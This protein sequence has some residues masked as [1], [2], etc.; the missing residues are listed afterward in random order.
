MRTLDFGYISKALGRGS[1]PLS[2]IASSVFALT[3][4]FYIFTF[5][6]YFKISIYTLQNR[7]TYNTSFEFYIIDKYID[8][9]IVISGTVLWLILCLKGKAR[10]IASGI[11]GAIIVI[12]LALNQNI[13]LDICA[14]V[15]V[16]LMIFFLIRHHMWLV[17][18]DK[19]ISNIQNKLSLNYLAVIGIIT[20]TISI[21]MILALILIPISLNSIPIPNYAYNIFVLF[22]SFSPVFLFL[23][24]DSFPTKLVIRELKAIVYKPK[25]K[26]NNKHNKGIGSSLLHFNSYIKPHQKLI[27]L[28]FFM[29]LSMCMV[30]IPHLPS[31]NADKQKVGVD[32][33]FYVSWINALIR[34]NDSWQFLQQAFN[35]QAHGDR[36]LTL[37]LLFAWAKISSIDL[38]Q[39]IEYVPLILGPMLVLAVYFLTRELIPNNDS[40]AL[41]ASFITAI[42]FQT[43]IGIYSGFYANWIALIV[44]YLALV[45]LLR[46]LKTSVKLNLV[47]FS[48]LMIVLLFAHVYTWSILIIVMIIFLVVS[49][50]LNYYRRKNIILLLVAILFSVVI[51]IGR[52]SLTGSSGGIYSDIQMAPASLNLQEFP[53]RW[54]TLVNVTQNDYGGQ[55]ANFI[56]LSCG[57]WWLFRSCLREPSTIFLMVFF[58]IGIIAL[59]FGQWV[60]Q[61]RIFYNIPFQIPAA[62]A[63]TYIKQTNRVLV[64]SICIWLVAM[65]IRAVSNFHLVSS[66]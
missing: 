23:L 40:A 64:S 45:F 38:F 5:G 41:F 12:A 21:I 61:S 16:P 44:G 46:F 65:S 1:P 47:V 20:G 42:S 62:I 25:I 60:V 18:K 33:H 15:S 8:H 6:S 63:L 55:F 19:D 36:P 35:I 4:F 2:I 50:V 29:V 11:Y 56:V 39:T 52:M 10:I 34:S 31:I 7:A 57:L 43:L 30:I 58:S 22:S 49:L 28:S 37:I 54:G 32:T 27:Y 66:T 24:V 48:S 26:N 14:L 59:F 51:D 17:P 3:C 9:L 53:Q 13:L